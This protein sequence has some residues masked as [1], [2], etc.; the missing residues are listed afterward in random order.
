MKQSLRKPHP[1]S[2]L[3]TAKK[4]GDKKRFLYVGDLPD[5]V[6]A[7]NHAKSSIQIHSVAFPSL[8]QEPKATLNEILKVKPDF[9]IKKP[10]ELLPVIQ[11]GSQKTQW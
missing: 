7:A 5:D 8:A 3:E 2:I 9:L 11:K 1:F 4:I 6:L 10:S